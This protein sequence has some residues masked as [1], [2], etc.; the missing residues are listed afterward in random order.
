M[1]YNKFMSIYKKI[2]NFFIIL[3]LLLFP[4]SKSKAKSTFR[5]VAYLASETTTYAKALSGCLLYKSDD[6]S[7][8]YGNVYFIIPETYF[9]IVLDI[10]DS[11]DKIMKVQYDRFVGYVDS[12]TVTV[13]TFI[14]KVKT[15]TGVTVDIKD[16]SGTQIW[17]EPSTKSVEQYTL[18]RNTK[19]IEYIGSVYGEIPSGGDNNLWYY[20]SYT[21]PTNKTNVYTGYIYSENAINLSEIIPN[22]ETNPDTN[23][24]DMVGNDVIYIGSPIK[25]VIIALIAIPIILLIAIMLYKIVK[26]FR[27]KRGTKYEREQFD[28]LE[29]EI[30]PTYKA[31]TFEP[32]PINRENP[33]SIKQRLADLIKTTFVKKN[34]DKQ[35]FYSYGRGSDNSLANCKNNN[36]YNAQMYDSNANADSGRY[37]SGKNFSPS[38][39]VGNYQNQAR[40]NQNQSNFARNDYHIDNDFGD[41]SFGSY[42]GRIYG[43]NAFDGNFQNDLNP[44]FKDKFKNDSSPS[45]RVHGLA[46]NQN[47]PNFPAYETDDDLL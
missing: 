44:S 11:S 18:D 30:V 19:N 27:E 41:D 33:H 22:T 12:S 20:V 5:E 10:D 7:Q 16:T 14:P 25:T 3:N 36:F 26:Y 45:P 2:F 46:K 6:L 40:F 23:S 4:L 28:T 15:L 39:R 37:E 1:K 34:Q 43:G 35:N 9:V 29:T 31:Y 32:K 17:S 21:P 24:S 38:G 8:A 42:A 13:A 47:Y